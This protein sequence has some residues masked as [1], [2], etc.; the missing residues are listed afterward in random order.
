ME[1]GGKTGEKEGEGKKQHLTENYMH[2]SEYTNWEG[3]S[4]MFFLQCTLL[5]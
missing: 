5:Y 1:E 3:D 4:T 2:R